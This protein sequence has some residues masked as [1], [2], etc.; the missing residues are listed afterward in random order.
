[1]IAISAG[2]VNGVDNADPVWLAKRRRKS[3]AHPLR[4]VTLTHSHSL[5]IGVHHACSVTHT[6]VDAADN[7][8]LEMC[9][10]LWVNAAGENDQHQSMHGEV[11]EAPVCT[12][13]LQASRA[14]TTAADATTAMS[15]AKPAADSTTVDLAIR[16]PGS[17]H[18][19]APPVPLPPFDQSPCPRTARLSQYE[20]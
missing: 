17:I 19:I 11:P 1:M 14:R 15:T 8:R 5:V 6:C 2:D 9:R 4:H 10:P 18:W 12:E 20:P 7:Q 16:H 3:G 13:Q